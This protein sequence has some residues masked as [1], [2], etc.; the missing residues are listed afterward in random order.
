[1]HKQCN[2][3]GATPECNSSGLSKHLKSPPSVIGVTSLKHF[4]WG[5][6]GLGPVIINISCS[7]FFFLHF[8]SFQTPKGT[9]LS[10][11]MRAGLT[12]VG[13]ITL[14]LNWRCPAEG[15]TGA[16]NSIL[17]MKFTFARF[18][19]HSLPPI[20][21]SRYWPCGRIGVTHI[22]QKHI[23]HWSENQSTLKCFVH[24]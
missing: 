13:T 12:L 11:R 1:M 4:F 20:P 17:G 24:T 21:W 8:H 15:E 3:G 23:Q 14:Y 9:D 19:I 7:L 5:H 10:S 6:L 2:C 22:C 16:L 18:P